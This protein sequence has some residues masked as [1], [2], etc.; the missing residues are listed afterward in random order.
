MPTRPLS[1]VRI[2]RCIGRTSDTSYEPAKESLIQRR[3]A[4]V[5]TGGQVLVWRIEHQELLEGPGADT[6]GEPRSVI[7]PHRHRR[8]NTGGSRLTNGSVEPFPAQ[9]QFSLTILRPDQ[10]SRVLS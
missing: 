8:C 6:R 1:G 2:A 4:S 9:P 10:G 5:I 7:L 3:V